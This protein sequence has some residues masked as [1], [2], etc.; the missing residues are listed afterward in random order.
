LVIYLFFSLYLPLFKKPDRYSSEGPRPLTFG[1]IFLLDS[2]FPLFYTLPIKK[3]LLIK[4]ILRK[5]PLGRKILHARVLLRADWKN[6]QL[7]LPGHY[8]SP[9]P[10]FEEILRNEKR[11]F[12]KARRQIPGI[13]L[14][15]EE[16]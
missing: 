6:P 11:I 16:Q 4:N 2:F 5:L 12:S 7:V 8:Y 10:D 15:Q 3:E 13:D 9:I 1:L 14:N